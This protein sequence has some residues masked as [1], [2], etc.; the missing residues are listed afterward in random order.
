MDEGRVDYELFMREAFEQAELALASGEVPVGCVVVREGRV[1]ARGHNLGQ[2]T[3]DATR[4]AET[5]ALATLEDAR[6]C[7]LVVTLEPC[8]MCASVLRQRFVPRVVFGASND[9]FGG[10]GSVA[11][12]LGEL[13]V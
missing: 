11:N 2:C 12:V 7:T 5:V 10:C 8:I 1:V 13:H 4:H 3:R 9:R 6:D